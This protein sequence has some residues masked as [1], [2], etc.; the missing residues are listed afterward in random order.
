VP[1]FL[2][3]FTDNWKLK[4]L[5]IALTLLLWVVVSAEQ[6]TS[7][8]IPVPL[9][10]QVTDSGYRLIA[11]SVPD[12][13]QV[14][15]TGPGRDFLDLAIRRSPLL[16]SV[17]EVDDTLDV[18]A[19]EPGMVQTSNQL[20]AIPNDVRPR[21]ITLRFTEI[22]DD[23]VPVAVRVR[24]EL[25]DEWTVVGDVTVEPSTV[26][27]RGPVRLVQ[28]VDTVYTDLVTISSGDSVFNRDVALDT[29]DLAGVRVTP[30]TVQVS[31]EVDRIIEATLEGVPI[32]VGSGIRIQ[33]ATVAVTLQG[34]ERAVRAVT[35]TSLRIAVA[36]DSIPSRLPAT[37]LAAPLRIEG[38]P[39]RVLG[40]PDPAGVRILPVPQPAAAA[41]ADTSAVEPSSSRR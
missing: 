40:R 28:R 30:D 11:S 14:R 3:I 2:R 17:G 20:S 12:E 1:K 35:A 22:A 27:L 15:F 34:P 13:V 7:S 29:D 4:L 24:N 18:F 32:S 19:L 26:R 21:T 6:V 16:L 8:W 25:E 10:V 36:L 9:E 37:G 33:P 5:A 41:A 23:L 39:S 38:L 31:G